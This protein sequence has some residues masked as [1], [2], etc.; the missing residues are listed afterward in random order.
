MNTEIK[1]WH[2]RNHKLFSV[3]DNTQIEELCI[4]MSYKK[5]HKGEIIYF[6]D[7]EVKRIYFLKKGTIK[8]AE[9]GEN[10]NEA[11]REIL[12]QGD[13][14]GEITLDQG[15]ETP[16]YAQAMS[17]EVVICSFRLEDFEQLL[18]K[19]PSLALKFTKLVGFRFKR[20]KNSYSNLIF[21]DVRTRLI[22]FLKDWAEK[23]G[24]KNGTS[25]VL[26][27]FLTHQDLASLVCSTRQTVTQLMNELEDRGLIRY[28][29]KE[30]VIPDL[31]HLA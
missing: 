26:E 9:T 14:F 15:N 6:A 5:A 30:I 3:L 22:A 13:L 21:K 16:E 2:L 20:L 23:E 7:E 10:G 17:K 25:V 4:I 8:I 19:Y 18:E 24:I 27:N 29:R 12:Q 31:R 11:I 28:S 1:Y